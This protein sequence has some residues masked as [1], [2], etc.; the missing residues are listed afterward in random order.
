MPP[1][2]TSGDL[3]AYGMF[4]WFAQ[5]HKVRKDHRGQ[6]GDLIGG[7]RA[8]TSAPNT[9]DSECE[10]EELFWGLDHKSK[11]KS[12]RRSAR[13]LI[14]NVALMPPV[15]LSAFTSWA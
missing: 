3:P 6:T 14:P 13:P 15:R 9:E 5:V 8:N 4:C 1:P 2:L 7:P 11:R 12:D 10:V